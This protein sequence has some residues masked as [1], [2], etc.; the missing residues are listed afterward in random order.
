MIGRFAMLGIAALLLQL[1]G[2]KSQDFSMVRADDCTAKGN[3]K[4]CTLKVQVD[5]D[6]VKK[7]CTVKVAPDEIEFPI[8]GRKKAKFITWEIV[9]S[10][11]YVF[12]DNGIVIEKNLPP[13]FDKPKNFGDKFRWRNKH[14]LDKE[15]V[16]YYSILVEKSDGSISCWQD[17]RISNR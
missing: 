2:C 1:P 8:E 3:L 6:M 11:G 7:T 4:D 9:G 13:D 5:E 14:E 15:K 16:Y 17:P 10:P 12:P